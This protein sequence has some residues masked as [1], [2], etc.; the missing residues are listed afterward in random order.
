MAS[1]LSSLTQSYWAPR[2]IDRM[3][4]SEFGG[5]H[6]LPADYY[7]DWIEE[8][9]RK[10]AAEDRAFEKQQRLLKILMLVAVAALFIV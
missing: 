1:S 7:D 8:K 9:K 3:I 5:P 6:I 10:Y 2:A 4:M